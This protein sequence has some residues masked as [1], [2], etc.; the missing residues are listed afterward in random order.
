MKIKFINLFFYILL[1]LFSACGGEGGNG[2]TNDTDNNIINMPAELRGEWL[3]V[4]SGEKIQIASDTVLDYEILDDDLLKVTDSPDNTRH[5]IRCGMKDAYVKGKVELLSSSKSSQKSKSHKKSGVSGIGSIDIVLDNIKDENL[6]T[7]IT[8]QVDGSFESSDVVSGTYDMTATDEDGNIIEYPQITIDEAKTDLGVF[9]IT[10]D[11]RLYNFKTEIIIDDEYLY[12]DQTYSGKIRIY[13]VGTIDALGLNY[14]IS[15]DDEYV[16]TIEYENVIGTVQQGHY[17]D[18]PISISFNPVTNDTGWEKIK[19]NVSINDSLLNTWEDYVYLDVYR[20][21]IKINIDTAVAGVK[22]YLI[23]PG[24]KLVHIDTSSSTIEVPYQSDQRYSLVLS[25]PNLS[26]ETA[27]SIG[28]GADTHPLEGFSDTASYEK[29]NT[30]SQATTINM[31]EAIASYLHVG[32]IDFYS[33]DMSERPLKWSQSL[34]TG[35]S[36]GNEAVGDYC[37]IAI[38]SNDKIHLSYLDTSRGN[39][40]YANNISG[41]WQRSSIDNSGGYTSISIDSNNYVHISYIDSGLKYATNASGSWVISSVD[42]NT[43]GYTSISIDSNDKAHISYLDSYNRSLK[44]ATNNSG[45]WVTSTIDNQEA[46]GNY[47]SIAIDSSNNIH[48]S[49]YDETNGDLKY[50]TNVSG[51]WV[52]FLIDRNDNVGLY[53]SITID[54]NDNVHISYKD[55]SKYDLKYATNNSGA[56]VT[57]TIDNQ[58]ILSSGDNS[59]ITVD[60]NNN[61]HISYRGSYRGSNLLLKYAT[62]ASGRWGIFTIDSSYRTAYST[63]IAIDSSN[64]VHISY[65]DYGY[66][67]VRGDRNLMY[68]YIF[69]K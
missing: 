59:S 25:N 39:V 31:N 41:S 9:T 23:V 63:S 49:Y 4:D 58:G 24:H 42:S 47:S 18:I 55:S 29:N 5:L 64:N 51:S 14:N 57:S 30:E 27:Y 38:D 15:S 44:Y 8:S 60:S 7:T 19:I 6:T 56:W 52:I 28:V 53:S 61:V 65:Y 33:I 32:D 36:F 43:M 26:D 3:Y 16:K 40:N 50:A 10:E 1:L 20:T 69:A 48:I 2:G 34:I 68:A 13:N 21:T 67:D 66:G 54:S 17:Q 35:N 45:A 37:S 46:V 11:G 12:D 62:N 22:G